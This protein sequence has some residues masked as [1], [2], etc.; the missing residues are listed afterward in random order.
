MGTI[1]VAKH[2][3]HIVSTSVLCF[4]LLIFFFLKNVYQ[5]TFFCTCLH[6]FYYHHNTL[7]AG[8]DKSA[9]NME[10]RLKQMSCK[11]RSSWCFH[12][13]SENTVG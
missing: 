2:D 11:A 12:R 8:S 6:V 10:T 9:V 1:T 5:G 4:N 7:M 13:K 3:K